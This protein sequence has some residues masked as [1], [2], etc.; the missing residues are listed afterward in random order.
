MVQIYIYIMNS[1]KNLNGNLFH[2]GSVPWPHWWNK[3]A[4][5]SKEKSE[6]LKYQ[7]PGKGK[8]FFGPC[9]KEMRSEIRDNIDNNPSRPIYIVGL[10][11]ANFK[12]RRIVYYMEI[13]RKTTF[14]DAYNEYPMLRG[15]GVHIKPTKTPVEYTFNYYGKKYVNLKYKHLGVFQ[16]CKK[17]PH[18]NEWV[19]DIAGEQLNYK[20]LGPD[21]CFL[22]SR[23]SVFFGNK[24]FKIDEEF[25]KKLKN[26]NLYRGDL[27]KKSVNVDKP[28]PTPRGN[29]LVLKRKIASELLEKLENLASHI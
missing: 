14:R 24:K 21:C 29:H 7:K 16:N 18:T 3:K 22:G 17:A 19:K 20:K 4:Y 13:E 25:C 26:G 6:R 12:P 1:I 9:K 5:Y 8:I 27:N 23:N 2:Y 11:N 28:I 15:T 10:S